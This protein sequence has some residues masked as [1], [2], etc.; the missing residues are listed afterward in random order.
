MIRCIYG[1]T[2]V[3]ASL[4]QQSQIQ[5]FMFAT[6]NLPS[7]F[8]VAVGRDVNGGAVESVVSATG[9]TPSGRVCSTPAVSFQT[10][11]R[12]ELHLQ[13]NCPYGS[14]ISARYL[15]AGISAN[16]NRAVVANLSDGS[17]APWEN[18]TKSQRN[19]DQDLPPCCLATAANRKFL[20]RCTQWSRR[21]SL[22]A[23][24]FGRRRGFAKTCCPTT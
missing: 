2:G 23:L 1:Q 19:D 21:E 6:E 8:D 11:M 7:H 13:A 9:T 18:R 16:V 14:L 4:F 24:A 10:G 3:L 17:S 5:L 12:A 15:S 22:V 20:P